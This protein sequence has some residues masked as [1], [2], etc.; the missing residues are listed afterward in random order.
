MS[1]IESSELHMANVVGSGKGIDGK[2]QMTPEELS[3]FLYEHADP[4][5]KA[6]RGAAAVAHQVQI[7]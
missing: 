7:R 2:P 5:E 4:N 3:A 1:E 6:E